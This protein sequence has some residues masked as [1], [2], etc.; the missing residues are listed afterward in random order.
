[1]EERNKKILWISLAVLLL[2]LIIIV[3]F[4][5]FW[6]RYEVKFDTKGGSE[7]ETVMV[8]WRGK[9]KRPEDPTREGYIFA[10]WYYGEEEFDFDTAIT[11]DMLIEAEWEDGEVELEGISLNATELT[12]AP[13]GT[14]QIKV[15]PIPEN[16]KE[17]E[18]VWESS[19][20]SIVT[21]DENGNVKAIKEG[22]AVI[23]VKTADGRYS[24]TCTVTVSK[25]V[26]GV[27]G[28][29]ISGDKE[30]RVGKTIKLTAKVSPENATNKQVTW[31]SSNKRVA[32][33]DQ[34]GVVKG[35]KEGKVTITVTT[36]DGEKVATYQ[37][38]VKA[39]EEAQKP[40]EKPTQTPEQ[41]PTK[42]NEPVQPEEPSK[43][44]DKTVKVTGVTVSGSTHEVYEGESIKLTA[45]VNPDN[46]TNKSVSWS[47][48]DSNVAEVGADGTVRGLKA[49]K[50]TITVKTADGEYTAQYEVTVKAKEIKVTGVTVSGST[51]EMN[52]GGT[53]KLTAKVS[54]ENATNKK[55]TWS[56]S[57]P[58]VATVDQ[59]GTVTGKGEGKV[60][61]TVTTEDGKKQATYE[62]TVK[63]V[64]K[65]ILTALKKETEAVFNYRLRVT[66]DGETFTEYKGISYN[67]TRSAFNQSELVPVK[68]VNTAVKKAEI[69]LNNGEKVTAEVEYK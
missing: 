27:E 23:T 14:G 36:V 45:K 28:V 22:T 8:R 40:E 19:D 68:T 2:L 61:I 1:M 57:N 21:V 4:L 39:A 18:L 62:V 69:I 3:I 37:I 41:T 46:A 44:E 63:S 48:S 60:T 17:V 10:G 33:V 31:S 7:I 67:G 5:L 32:T 66:K 47:S 50:V 38:T 54:P 52:V 53:L 9:V 35:I 42:P 6:P 12:L 58:S 65:M 49:G 55:V 56:S 59:N 11:K 26:V 13:E 43:P 51:H 34:N 20:E 15:I 30:V 64:Y 25:E 16:A 29:E 24:A